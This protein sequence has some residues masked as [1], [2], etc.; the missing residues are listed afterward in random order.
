MHIER[1]LKWLGSNN[2]Q[3][4]NTKKRRSEF[5]PFQFREHCLICVCECFPKDPKHPDRW[6]KVKQYQTK[7]MKGELLDICKERG[8]H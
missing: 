8:I 1:E 2:P 5:E 4:G 6:R 3:K 7:E